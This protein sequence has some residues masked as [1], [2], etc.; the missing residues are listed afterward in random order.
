MEVL[1]ADFPQIPPKTIHDI[2]NLSAKNVEAARNE[3]TLLLG[4]ADDESTLAD[5]SSHPTTKTK[6]PSVI[7]STTVPQ[8]DEAILL[9]ISAD[10][11]GRRGSSDQM[12]RASLAVGPALVGTT[13]QVGQV[14]THRSPRGQ[15]IITAI[16]SQSFYE[17]PNLECVASAGLAAARANGASSVVVPLPVSLCSQRDVDRLASLFSSHANDQLT[18]RIYSALQDQ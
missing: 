1:L 18:V 4:L 2:F 10:L 8:R 14:H 5:P 6:L 12:F 9:C 11:A 7:V 17:A 16:S 3:L 13:L 15:L